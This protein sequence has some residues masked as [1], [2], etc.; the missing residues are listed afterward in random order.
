LKCGF[1]KIVVKVYRVMYSLFLGDYIVRIL[2]YYRGKPKVQLGS[3]VTCSRFLPGKK[4]TK[5]NGFRLT[6]L[7]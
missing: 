1:I 5:D 3:C 7:K 4:Q 6:L 2:K